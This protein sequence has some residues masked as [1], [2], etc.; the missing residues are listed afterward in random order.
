MAQIRPH[1]TPSA[2]SAIELVIEDFTTPHT[3]MAVSAPSRMTDMMIQNNT[4]LM[5]KLV[6]ADILAQMPMNQYGTFD[7]DKAAEIIELGRT[8]MREAIDKYES[9]NA[10]WRL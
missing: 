9:A 8:L 3:M 4:V 7:F 1:R 6:K 10:D 2:G 5:N